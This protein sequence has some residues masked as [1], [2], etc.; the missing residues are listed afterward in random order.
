MRNFTTGLF[1]PSGLAGRAAARPPRVVF[2]ESAGR[3]SSAVGNALP[4]HSLEDEEMA[5]PAPFQVSIEV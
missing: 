5:V 1:D 2:A 3:F 4:G